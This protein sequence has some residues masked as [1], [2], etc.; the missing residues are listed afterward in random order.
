MPDRPYQIKLVD[1]TTPDLWRRGFRSVVWVAPTGAGKTRMAH[2][3]IRKVHDA[4]WAQRWFVAHTEELI[5]QP[6]D[7]F[8]GDGIPH[9]FI[10][11]GRDPDPNCATQI[12]QV[13]TMINRQLVVA[14]DRN[15]RP[16]KRAIV[17]I[18]E[19]HHV[20]A[21]TYLRIRE[22]LIA[23]YELIYFILLTATPYRRDG[24]GLADVAD[25]LV[26][27][28][29]PRELIDNGWLVDPIY[30]ATPPPPENA[31]PQVRRA[32]LVGDVVDTWKRRSRGLPTVGRA[33]NIAHSLALVER[34]RAQGVR[35][36]HIDGDTPPELRRELY[37]RLAIGGCAS[38]HPEAIDVLSTG[39]T[40]FEEGFDSL[41]SYRHVLN[42]KR[43]WLGK[44]YPP[45]YRP[46]ACLGDWAPSGAKAA[47]IQ[48][49]GRVTRMHGPE[50][51]AQLLAQGVE[52]DLKTSAVVL[53]HSGNLDTHRHLVDHCGFG[54]EGDAMGSTRAASTAR[55][56]VRAPLSCPACFAVEPAGTPRC[57]ACGAELAAGQQDIPTEDKSVEL[58]R[59]DWSADAA[60]R[61]PDTPVAMERTLKRLY[62]EQRQKNAERAAAGLPPYKDG[63]ARGRFFALH[64]QWPPYEMEQAIRRALGFAA[65]D[66]RR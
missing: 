65:I 64:R 15:G 18:D 19:A 1:Q 32:R 63:W 2:R 5:D 39:G 41:K 60:P 22:R 62:G 10:K 44:S 20:K 7:D 34:F 38:D 28:T 13:Q 52:S 33:I 6:A 43:L 27:A 37:A 47:W 26:E 42:I 17:F 66:R 21:S 12:C 40:I 4:D 16:Y 48:R 46:L 35:A 36:E 56:H 23:L 25:A 9:A 51:V 58:V 59:R 29:T 49:V 54:L 30:F 8:A 24:R 45:R 3:L 61:L 55:L 53:C 57:R 31:E 11:A 14:P 50:Q